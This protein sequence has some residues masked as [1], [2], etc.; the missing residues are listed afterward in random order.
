MKN[1]LQ[2]SKT[3][4]EETRQELLE[5]SRQET[6]VPDLFVDWFIWMLTFVCLVFSN[7]WPRY[8]LGSLQEGLGRVTLRPCVLCSITL[9]VLIMS[10]VVSCVVG[11]V[12]TALQ[13]VILGFL[14]AWNPLSH[15]IRAG[16]V[17]TVQRR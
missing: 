11:P 2:R 4:R 17:Y 13:R 7:A 5:R 9:A 8:L 15:G 14:P 3:G 16:P 1:G 6:V 12:P 10:L